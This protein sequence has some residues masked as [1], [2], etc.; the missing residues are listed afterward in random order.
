MRRVS[1]LLSVSIIAPLLLSSPSIWAADIPDVSASDVKSMLDAKEKF[2]LVNALS[3]IE[4]KLEH[5]PGSINIPAGE[6]Q[7]TDKLPQDKG[8]LIVFY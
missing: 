2:L 3:D 6:I 4:F 1:L 8:A 7:T 5:I